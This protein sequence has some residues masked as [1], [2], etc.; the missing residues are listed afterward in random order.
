MS[1]EASFSPNAILSS[2]KT[3]GTPGSITHAD[4]RRDP[5]DQAYSRHRPRRFSR[6]HEAA[7]Q[8]LVTSRSRAY[9]A[10]SRGIVSPAACARRN[11]SPQM[12]S[13]STS[14]PA[15]KSTRLEGL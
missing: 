7:H 6:R 13:T 2:E 12:A 1:K 14:R 11:G 15:R 9:S 5:T 10:S 8:R 4:F 3:A